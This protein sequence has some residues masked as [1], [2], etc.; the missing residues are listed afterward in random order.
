[1]I[2]HFLNIQELNF[3]HSSLSKFQISKVPATRADI[4]DLNDT[5]NEQ[6]TYRQARPDGICPIRR[7]LADQSFG[8]ETIKFIVNLRNFKTISLV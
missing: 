5:L 1:M 2:R 4:L 3:I 7:E 8:N 6:L